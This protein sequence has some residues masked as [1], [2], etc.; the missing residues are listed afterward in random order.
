MLKHIFIS[1]K[2]KKPSVSEMDEGMSENGA[3]PNEVL[4]RDWQFLKFEPIHRQYLS[5][6]ERPELSV[7]SVYLSFSSPLY[8]VLL[9]LSLV[10]VAEEGEEAEK[11]IKFFLL[12]TR[13]L[14]F[15]LPA[16]AEE[17]GWKLTIRTRTTLKIC[18]NLFE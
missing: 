13:H 3:N 18:K 6:L 15:S 9:F 1:Q 11:M 7:K 2:K 4:E 14:L 5:C 16:S 17:G 12:L 10:V 8:C